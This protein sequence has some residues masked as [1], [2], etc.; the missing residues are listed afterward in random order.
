[1]KTSFRMRS[2]ALTLLILT[3]PGVVSAQAEFTARAG[4]T[5]SSTLVEDEIA[6]S[7]PITVKAGLA[8][9]LVLGASLPATA[10]NRVS[11]EL[12]FA[13]STA[14]VEDDSGE[15]DL[16]DLNTI[17][18]SLGFDGPLTSGVRW[19]A[20]AGALKYAPSEEVGVFREGGSWRWQ[21]GAGVDWARKLSESLDFVAAI[22]YDYHRFTTDALEANG[23]ANPEG[24]HRIAVTVG[25]GGRP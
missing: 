4:V 10:T 14:T 3:T 8:P 23:F 18:V 9:T 2:T 17:G 12:A 20:G 7:G 13:R 1:M 24:V 5:W 15:H 25:I 21:A 16:A 22:R 19:R 11:L 6:A